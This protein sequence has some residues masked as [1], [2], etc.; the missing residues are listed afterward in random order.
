MLRNV[1]QISL[2]ITIVIK[3][4]RT[5]SLMMGQSLDCNEWRLI[6]YGEYQH[7]SS[8]Y[9]WR[10]WALQVLLGWYW[11]HA[12][13]IRNVNG[14]LMSLYDYGEDEFSCTLGLNIC[15]LTKGKW[16]R[17]NPIAIFLHRQSELERQLLI[18]SN[19]KSFCSVSEVR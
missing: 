8:D 10:A 14:S 19:S 18:A 11:V 16:M 15:I 9:F 13:N 12:K 17:Q 3:I 7:L 4:A 1:E 6:W 5:S 2:L